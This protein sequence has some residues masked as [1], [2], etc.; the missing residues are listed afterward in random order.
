M[1]PLDIKKHG[2][3][4]TRL[5]TTLRYLEHKAEGMFAF[6]QDIQ[7]KIM[8][9][10]TSSASRARM[11]EE[12]KATFEEDLR[13]ARA[14][15]EELRSLVSEKEDQLSEARLVYDELE[16]D[17]ND[18]DGRMREQTDVILGLRTKLADAIETVQA[19]AHL[20]KQ[21]HDLEKDVA[22][23]REQLSLASEGVRIADKELEN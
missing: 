22:T 19:T 1:H 21:T 3:T 18:V 10:G 12:L 14:E 5:L 7:A 4:L 17:M 16:D 2:Y 20:R 9:A 11:E 13:I 15:I 6:M 23:L 8:I